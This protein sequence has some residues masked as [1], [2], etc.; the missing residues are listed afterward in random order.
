[1]RVALLGQIAQIER[2][3]IDPISVSPET[4]YLGLEHIE[5]GG[6]ILGSLTV[7]EAGLLSTKFSFSEEHVLFGKLRPYLAK[8]ARPWFAGVCST[9]ILPIRPG[10]ELDRDYL[11]HY[12]RQP[13]VVSLATSQATGANLPRLSPTALARFEI[14]VPAL[15]EQQ[16]IAKILD[17]TDALRANRR[18]TLLLIDELV[19][20]IYHELFD[21]LDCGSA[22]LEMVAEAI[23]D[24]PHTTPKWTE[25]GAV[26]LRTSNLGKGTWDWT[27]TKY[28]SEDDYAS[29]SSRGEVAAGDIILSRE[30][31]VGIAAVVQPGMKL[32][33]GQ[34]LVQVRPDP[35]I[36]EPEY[37]L[38]Y[39]LRVL[40]PERIG[41]FMVGSTSRHLNVRDLRALEVPLPSRTLQ[42]E[43][44]SRVGTAAVQRTGLQR[45]LAALDRLF[46]SLQ[47]RAF[48]GQ[49]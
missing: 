41:H 3:G 8:I 33:M 42:R 37:L 39:L 30:G 6:R 38:S 4:R 22:P 7:G 44:A 40:A 13:S 10:R 47:A 12:L 23:N 14:P 27:D 17:Q 49:L 24:C 29:R 11:A 48:S 46:A 16:R 45:S 43:Y 32:C 26:C 18:L 20:S 19:G 5:R 15:A 34:R 1:M 25:D 28:V 35:T 2:A 36:V 21:G 9:D 31:T